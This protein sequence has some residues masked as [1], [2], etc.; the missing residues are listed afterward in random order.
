MARP[1]LDSTVEATLVSLTPASWRTFS[2]RWITRVR[3]LISAPITGQVAE[4][5]DVGWGDEARPKQSMF[6]QLS[7]PR[8]VGHVG[9]ATWH[10]LHVR[11]IDQ[12][13]LEVEL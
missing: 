4:L 6:C 13:H 5:A 7:D 1:D 8:S 11:R 12:A 9:L 2:R 10:V 3:S